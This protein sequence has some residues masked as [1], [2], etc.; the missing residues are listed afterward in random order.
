MTALTEEQDFTDKVVHKF[1]FIQDTMYYIKFTTKLLWH[2]FPFP[3]FL[4]LSFFLV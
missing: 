4:P 3:M 2:H 1:K